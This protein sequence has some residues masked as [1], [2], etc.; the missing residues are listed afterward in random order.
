MLGPKR[1]EH[2]ASSFTF[3]RRD[4]S[5]LA[6][7]GEREAGPDVV[8]CQVR[9]VSEQIVLGHAGRQ[10]VEHVGNRHAQAADAWFAV[11]FSGLDRDPVHVR[12]RPSVRNVRPTVKWRS[13]SGD[14]SRASKRWF[15]RPGDRAARQC[16]HRSRRERVPAAPVGRRL[17]RYFEGLYMDF[18]ET[19]HQVENRLGV[20]A[21][22]RTGRAPE[23]LPLG[24]DHG[25]GLL[26]WSSFAVLADN[27][28][29][30]PR[31]SSRRRDWLCPCIG[32]S[33]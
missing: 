32:G 6:I 4:H 28:C 20:N 31:T 33:P 21:G 24:V 10:V 11:A 13:S 27:R 18:G 7:S 26:R 1:D 9:K 8:A 3:R 16:R 22:L 19:V 5:S 29:A 30:A 23:L 2:S 14:G 15:S 12:H 25:F 17:D